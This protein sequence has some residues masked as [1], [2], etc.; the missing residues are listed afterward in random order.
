MTWLAVSEQLDH[1]RLPDLIRQ[2]W[3]GDAGSLR[4]I[5]TG[6]NIVFRFES[7]GAG[8]Y[9][10]ISHPV[11]HSINEAEAT[12]AYLRHLNVSGT[13]VCAPVPARDGRFILPIDQDEFYAAV[14]EEVPG[15]PFALN[16]RDPAAFEAWGQSLGKLHAA[17]ATYSPAPNTTYKDIDSA[18]EK[19]RPHVE[20]HGGDLLRVFEQTEAWMRSLPRHPGVFG[21]THGDYRPGNVIWD[22]K[23]ARTV[24]FDEPMFNWYMVDFAR[25]LMEFGERPQAERRQIRD[26]FAA[27]YRAYFQ[28]DARLLDALTQFM[29]LRGIL[30]HAWILED[31]AQRDPSTITHEERTLF[32]EWAINP[33]DWS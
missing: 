8:R 18:W 28:L 26:A 7:D 33:V 31:L 10:R 14:V 32:R 23:T 4:Y 12:L 17:A 2:T 16:T 27:G 15:V 21:L 19:V 30:M 5:N 1:T 3:N 20:A 24:D 22:G 29:Q 25:A 6:A 13:H 11:L 9:M